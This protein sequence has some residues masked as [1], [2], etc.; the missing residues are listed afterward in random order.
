M[1]GG[2][3]TLR[4]SP[5]VVATPPK[6]GSDDARALKVALAVYLAIFVGKFITYLVTGVMAMLAEALHTLSDIV[7]AGFLLTAIFYGRKRSDADHMFG[8]GRAQN[9]AGLIA[10]TLFIAF[11]AYQLYVEAIPRLFSSA[12]TSYQNLGLAVGVLVASILILA[13]PLVGLVRQ[14]TRGAAAKAQLL[15]FVN[16]VVGLL[17]ALVATLFIITGQPVADP[18]ASI[19][20]ATIITY[21]G[22]GLLRD[23]ASFLLGR[24]PGPEDLAKLEAAARSVPGVLGVHDLR[25]EYVGP[26]QLHAGMHLEVQPGLPVEQANR[27]ADAVRRRVHDATDASYCVIQVEAAK[28]AAPKATDTSAIAVRT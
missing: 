23:N 14:K 24:A 3:T 6:K 8:H 4:S 9:V 7:I 18:L 11:T 16:D 1:G 15:G 13:W 21:N 26:N 19:V 20:V 12:E 2:L 25:A 22:I 10:A 27:I 5:G 17:A 28:P